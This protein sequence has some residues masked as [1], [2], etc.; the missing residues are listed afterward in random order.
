MFSV[1]IDI[2]SVST[3]V[4]VMDGENNVLEDRYIRNFGQPI[5]IVLGFFR[6]LL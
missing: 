6:E 5:Q 3:D 4:V 1:G 2:G